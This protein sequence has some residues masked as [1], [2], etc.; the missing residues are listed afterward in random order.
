MLVTLT[1]ILLALFFSAL[2][3]L[4]TAEIV[5][6]SG[7]LSATLT[8]SSNETINATLFITVED[9]KN[10]TRIKFLDTV[11][12]VAEPEK[13]DVSFIDVLGINVHI[14]DFAPKQTI[15]LR[16][17]DI[18]V[19][20]DLP[21]DLTHV[22]VDFGS[23]EGPT[24]DFDREIIFSVLARTR[25]GEFSVA[26]IRISNYR[27]KDFVQPLQYRRV[28]ERGFLCIFFALAFCFVSS[29]VIGVTVKS[30][31][32]RVPLATLIV[33]LSSV[34]IYSFFGSGYEILANS[35]STSFTRA[36][37]PISFLLHGYDSHL[38][39]N[40]FFFLLVSLLMESWL[41][42]RKEWKTFLIWYVAPMFL[43]LFSPGIGLSLS[44]ESM[45]WSLWT[46][47]I[48]EKKNSTRLDII[49][50]ILAGLPAFGFFNWTIAYLQ[51][52]LSLYNRGLAVNH[53]AYGVISGIIIFGLYG[54]WW[55]KTRFTLSP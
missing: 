27:S 47:T 17:D 7:H 50:C 24:F 2:G 11:I 16:V 18:K 14:K 9:R 40:L 53:V 37:L 23:K 6:A 12:N 33:A 4:G 30:F 31:R 26:S 13:V 49:M 42:L 44:I 19:S 25:L 28:H 39:G 51:G 1:V 41:S 34:S 35:P 29:L 46:R 5:P 8:N 45:T 22:V 54:A 20:S 10:L 15:R 32:E 43:T 38:S 36:I 21:I 3:V 55:A 48:H 52:E